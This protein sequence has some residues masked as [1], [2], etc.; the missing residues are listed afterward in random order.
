MQVRGSEIL[1]VDD[2]PDNL[3]LIVRTLR[4]LA[5]LLTATSGAAALEL[6]RH[7]EI[8]VIV[9]DH[10]MPGLTG[11]ELLERATRLAPTAAR[12]LVTAY[13]DADVLT[14]AINRGHATHVLAKPIEPRE[15]RAIV[16]RLLAAPAARRALVLAPS[17]LAGQ[18]AVALRTAGL[19]A[20][21]AVEQGEVDDEIAV[22]PTGSGPTRSSACATRSAPRTRSA[23]SAGRSGW[24]R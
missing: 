18:I 5:P 22:W 1:V 7:R 11:V 23:A 15:L 8:G 3:E 24:P 20:G 6:L 9:T 4:G 13:G 21:I 2:E 16:A 17:E 19:S 14:D 12:I 10:A